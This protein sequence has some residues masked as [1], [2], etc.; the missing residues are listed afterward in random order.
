LSLDDGLKNN[1]MDINILKSTEEESILIDD[2]IISFNIKKVPHTQSENLIPLNFNVKNK[3][4]VMIAGINA[5][6][7]GWKILYIDVLFVDEE[8]RY[9]KIGSVL[10]KKIE[11]YAKAEGA[12]LVHLDTFDF[13]AK[14]FYLKQGYEIFGVLDDCP[15]NHKRYYL[16]KKLL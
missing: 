15:E 10:L 13:Q 1:N 16:K 9:Q 3:E 8:Y 7:Y 2:K 11:Q 14:D 4:G 5:F 12:K 6:L